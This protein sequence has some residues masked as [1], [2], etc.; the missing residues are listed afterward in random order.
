[1]TKLSPPIQF[2][3]IGNIESIKKSIRF[4]NW[5]DIFLTLLNKF[6]TL[7]NKFSTLLNKFS[8]LI[9]KLLTSID[10]VLSKTQKWTIYTLK[11]IN[12]LVW[13]RIS[14]KSMN[15]WKIIEMNWHGKKFIALSFNSI[16]FWNKIIELNCF[17][18]MK[19]KLK[20]PVNSIH[21]P[22]SPKVNSSQ[23]LNTR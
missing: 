2:N 17:S 10:L 5:I 14:E 11:T 12:D 3:N 16:Q 21:Y 8:T 15:Y 18:I 9:N 19:K 6:S 22:E 13:S 1:M 20:R 4:E 7:L 23:H